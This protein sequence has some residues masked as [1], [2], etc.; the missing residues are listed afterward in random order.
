MHLS[1]LRGRCVKKVLRFFTCGFL[2]VIGVMIGHLFYLYHHREFGPSDFRHPSLLGLKGQT[3][4][5]MK[6]EASQLLNQRFS[7]LGNGSQVTAFESE[8]RRYVIKFFNP[9]NAIKESWF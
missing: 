4:E 8:D 3:S 5:E 9:R 1:A 6:K 7:Y 2:A